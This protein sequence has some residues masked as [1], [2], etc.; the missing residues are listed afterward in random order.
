VSKNDHNLLKCKIFY[1]K[2]PPN[3]KGRLGYKSP[4]GTASIKPLSL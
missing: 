1:N 2:A 4:R 3:D